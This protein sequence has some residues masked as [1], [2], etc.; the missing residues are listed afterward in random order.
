LTGP[1]WRRALTFLAVGLGVLGLGLVLAHQVARGITGPI[2]RLRALATVP[3][4]GDAVPIDTGLPETDEVGEALLSE[5]RH[6]RAAMASLIDSERRLRL[7]IA[8]LNHRAKNALATVQ[9]LAQQ[10]V[11]G[12]AGTD[13][14]HF[15]T[16]F[17]A[18]LQSLARAHD[19][20]TAF[21]WENAALDAVVRAGVAPWIAAG[22]GAAPRVA[23]DCDCGGL[24]PPVSPGQAQALV[25]PLHELAS[26][27]ARLAHCPVPPAGSR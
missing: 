25:M 11:R 2:T 14:V 24:L 13:P 10:T 17:N 1:A 19:L 26:N 18:R 8:E 22:D 16:A 3:A 21:G 7:V 5:A 23:V 4:E 20:L 9:S 6:R 12:E 27:A 15:A